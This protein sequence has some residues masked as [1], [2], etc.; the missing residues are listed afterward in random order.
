[1]SLPSWYTEIAG[2]RPQGDS[3]DIADWYLQIHNQGNDIYTLRKLDSEEKQIYKIFI[4]SLDKSNSKFENYKKKI[5][6]IFNNNN[7][8]TSD[9]IILSSTYIYIVGP[10]SFN[11][12]TFCKVNKDLLSEIPENL[13]EY[14]N[15]I[16]KIPQFF[17]NNDLKKFTLINGTFDESDGDTED[18][19]VMLNNSRNVTENVK[20]NDKTTCV[21]R[22]LE[23]Y[24]LKIIQNMFRRKWDESEELKEILLNIVNNFNKYPYKNYYNKNHTNPQSLRG[25]FFD[26]VKSALSLLDDEQKLEIAEIIFENLLVNY[27]DKES[28]GAMID[29]LDRITFEDKRVFKTYTFRTDMPDY[30]KKFTDEEM[31]EIDDC[32]FKSGDGISKFIEL[33]KQYDDRQEFIIYLNKLPLQCKFTLPTLKYE[34]P[35]VNSA[36]KVNALPP[37]PPAPKPAAA[38]A[39]GPQASA[40]LPTAEELQAAAAAA[41]VQA[42]AD[43]EADAQVRADAARQVAEVQA[44]AAAKAAAAKAAAAAANADRDA[45][46]AA[47]AKPQAAPEAP[48]EPKI[49]KE[50]GA[51]PKAAAAEEVPYVHEQNENGNENENGNNSPQPNEGILAKGLRKLMGKPKSSY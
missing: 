51:P 37:E 38:N 26:S 1:M 14:I 34:E 42:A 43:R 35:K 24:L 40:K 9:K 6:N 29:E 25:H 33:Y 10:F 27:K 30:T 4:D 48:N 12:Y 50:D 46:A 16:C 13:K 41:E 2:L 8:S 49:S 39:A 7:L 31:E 22:E 5:F 15:N 18:T 32:F 3:K 21:Q 36:I 11:F 23:K 45:A 28:E 20:A 47:A 19:L 44:A 17:K